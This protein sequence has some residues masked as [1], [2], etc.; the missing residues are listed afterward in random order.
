MKNMMRLTFLSFVTLFFVGCAPSGLQVGSDQRTNADISDF[1]TYN[2]VSDIDEIP[3]NQ[4]FV[5]SKGVLIFNNESTHKTI[6]ETIETQLATKG[7]TRDRQDPDMLVNFKV[8]EED[9][10]L[11]TY[12]RDG[13]SY[14]GEGPVGRNV[15]MVD[16]EAGTV[17][18]NFINA[19]TGEQVWQ[20]FASGALE[21]SDAKDE[22][23][24]KRKVGALFDQ[25]DFSPF[26]AA[27]VIN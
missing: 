3:G 24:L 5:G 25:F 8:L 9:T 16:V 10:Q 13:Y 21:E 1:E 6:K 2:W 12:I 20:G 15:Q 14:V 22:T 17:I 26:T 7:F 23:T 18:L 11:R 27:N 4:I 19:E